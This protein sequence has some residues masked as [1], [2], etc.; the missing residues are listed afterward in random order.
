MFIKQ[1]KL[2]NSS[3]FTLIEMLVVMGIFGV[4]LAGILK[5]FDTS[6]YTYKVQ[7]EVA[8]MQQNVRV[9]KM[10]LEKDIRM[11]GCGLNNLSMGINPSGATV[12]TRAYALD[13][14][15]D[16]GA[17]GSDAIN[18]RILNYDAGS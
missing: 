8:E 17:K 11:A 5:V 9:S 3:G 2:F 14:F 18:I 7:E 4:V 10:F 12:N 13:F 16:D 1:N 15:N 6:N